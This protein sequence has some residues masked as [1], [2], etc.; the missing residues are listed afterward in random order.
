MEY[1]DRHKSEGFWST[2]VGFSRLPVVSTNCSVEPPCTKSLYSTT[3]FIAS[4]FI[5]HSPM[6]SH[7]RLYFPRTQDCTHTLVK[8]WLEWK[9]VTIQRDLNLATPLSKQKSYLNFTP[10]VSLSLSVHI[11]A[12]LA[13]RH[14]NN[15]SPW[16][17]PAQNLIPVLLVMYQ[18]FRSP[19]ISCPV[20]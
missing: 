11:L 4:F 15:P 3:C 16:Q 10:P 12:W 6:E 1:T 9:Q 14:D 7:P 17:Q 20:G 18:C 8:D 2:H 13:S 5:L 19:Q